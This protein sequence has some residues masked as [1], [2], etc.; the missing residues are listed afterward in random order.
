MGYIQLG[1]EG[2]ETGLPDV[3][4]KNVLFSTWVL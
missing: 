3:E 1:Q 2:K 4:D